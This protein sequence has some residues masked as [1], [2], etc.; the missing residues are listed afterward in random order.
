MTTILITRDVD[1][2]VISYEIQTP[3]RG[4]VDAMRIEELKPGYVLAADVV[5]AVS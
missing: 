3:P 4:L 1:G 2:V 5:G